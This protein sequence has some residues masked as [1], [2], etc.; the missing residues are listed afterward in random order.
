MLFYFYLMQ[1]A[2]NVPVQSADLCA[3]LGNVAV[4]ITL[5]SLHIIL[6]DQAIDILLDISHTKHTSAH[7]GLNDFSHEFLM[8]DQL[9]A[10]ENAD[11]SCLALEVTI[12]RNTNV[13]LLI[14]FFRLFKLHLVDLDAVFRMFE[15]LI[16]G[17]C[18]R[19]IDV[20]AFWMLDKRS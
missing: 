14:F 8:R 6:L 17:E 3:Y 19:I 15:T 4:H 12:F 1:K 11:D 5:L 16:D 20:S 10:L 2:D 7:G 13:C 18:V 9:A